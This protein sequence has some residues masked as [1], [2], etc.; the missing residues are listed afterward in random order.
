MKRAAVAF[1]DSFAK[2]AKNERNIPNLFYTEDRGIFFW[3]VG[4]YVSHI[5]EHQYLN[6][7]INFQDVLEN[8]YTSTE[9]V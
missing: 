5:T 7:N 6:S 8:L 2:A 3:N 4:I 9:S 1:S